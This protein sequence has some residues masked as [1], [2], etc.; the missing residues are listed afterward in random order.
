[1]IRFRMLVF[2][3]AMLICGYVLGLSG[4]G[5]APVTAQEQE[6]EISEQAATRILEGYRRLNDA[7][8]S[9]QAEGKYD[10]ITEGLNTFL[11]LA[12]GGNAREDLE[13]GRGVDPETFAALYAG[14]AVPEVQDL[15][16]TDD[17]GRITYNNEVVRMYSKS[18]L[19]RIFATRTQL[20]DVGF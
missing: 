19:E 20:T 15:L 5:M 13:S 1:M 18:R 6:L 7:R 17:Q 11:V 16:D 9:L 14:R 3:G 2:G 8:E 4:A 10:A 12:G